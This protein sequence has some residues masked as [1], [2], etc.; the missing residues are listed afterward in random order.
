MAYAPSILAIRLRQLGDV[1]A[2]LGSLRA[3]KESA[4]EYK[5][6][7]V[8]DS[9]YHGLLENV[10]YI[11][12]LLPQPPRIN[13]L[14]G[15]TAF[16]HYIEA[17][18]DLRA[19]YV[20]DFH[21]NTRSAILSF[22]T[23]APV[24]VGFDV[25]IRKVLYTDVEPRA[26][27]SNGK[28][29]PRT[30]HESALAL[31]R[32]CGFDNIHGSVQNT[33]T[34][35]DDQLESGRQALTATGIK[36]EAIENGDVVGLNPGNPYP[37]KAWP[38]D[39]FVDLAAALTKTGMSVLVLWGPGEVEVAR[40][41]VE[42][43]GGSTHLAPEVQLKELPG[44]LKSLGVIV[45]IDSGLKHLAVAVG[46]P[47]VTLFGPTNPYEWHMGGTR[48]RY[49]Y[50]GLSCSPCRLKECPIGNPCMIQITPE[51][52]FNEVLEFARPGSAS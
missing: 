39:N 17:I 50:E 4:P 31:I 7:F 29:M 51:R 40:R 42:R 35:P 52:V 24:R 32:R 47:T 46:V 36:R 19:Q 43:V 16:E 45:T 41:V 2:T 6:V 30:S 37:A 44:M 49:L 48:D 8:V 28:P 3:L 12:L 11:D 5:L 18:R 20:L 33:I 1:L 9:H 22:L 21:S 26:A 38:E 34:V 13:G 23:G 10:G 15:A 14:S 27:F 25:R